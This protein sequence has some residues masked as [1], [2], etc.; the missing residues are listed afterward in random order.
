MKYTLFSWRSDNEGG[1]GVY[2]ADKFTPMIGYQPN[3]GWRAEPSQKIG[4]FSNTDELIEVLLASDPIYTRETAEQ[5]AL[6]I[7]EHI[8]EIEMEDLWD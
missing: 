5:D 7:M 6:D 8:R 2:P 1:I 4:D 3:T